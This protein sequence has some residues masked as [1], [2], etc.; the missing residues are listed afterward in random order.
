M[1]VINQTMARHYWGQENPIGH[2]LSNDGG[3]TWATIVGVVGDVKQY[4]FDKPPTDELYAVGKPGSDECDEPA[5][6]NA[7]KSG[8]AGAQIGERCL[9]D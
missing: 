3:K 9:R 6:A 5:G 4:G 7:A 1:V 8:D 2:R